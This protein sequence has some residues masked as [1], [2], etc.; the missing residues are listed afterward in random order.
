[1]TITKTFSP[2]GPFSVGQ[3]VTYTYAIAN[4][5]N[6]SIQNVQVSDLHGAP[7][8]L[9]T[10]GGSGIKGE[11]LTNAGPQGA[12]ASPDT[13]PNDGI[14][15]VLSPGATVT[16]TWSHTVTQAEIDHG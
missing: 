12:A 7:P 8:T 5:G 9:V 4:N 14:W 1:M 3:I 2:A 16:F 13:T 10:V 6:V 15:S 11:T